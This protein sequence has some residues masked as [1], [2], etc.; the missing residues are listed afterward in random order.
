M[1]IFVMLALPG[2]PASSAESVMISH[3]AV[4]YE[5]GYRLPIPVTDNFVSLMGHFGSAGVVGGVR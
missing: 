5:R 1:L 4:I 3:V 2:E